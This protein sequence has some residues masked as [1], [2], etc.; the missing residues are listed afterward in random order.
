MGKIMQTCPDKR[1]SN[2][3][4]KNFKDT[5]KQTN[6]TKS[7]LINFFNIQKNLKQR[8]LKRN[9]QP[10]NTS[11]QVYVNNSL[12]LVELIELHLTPTLHH[13]NIK[14]PPL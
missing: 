9:S 12:I 4:N 3:I 5:I 14:F 10:I 2:I 1:I 11:I 6:E 13:I 7:S 8:K